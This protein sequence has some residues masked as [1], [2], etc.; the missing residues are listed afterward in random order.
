MLKAR[1][2]F[3]RILANEIAAEAELSSTPVA[4]LLA[5]TAG[6]LTYDEGNCSVTATLD[7]NGGVIYSA[8]ATGTGSTDAECASGA[9]L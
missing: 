1:P 3:K 5:N 2:V 4:G 6:T 9:G 8:A 7:V